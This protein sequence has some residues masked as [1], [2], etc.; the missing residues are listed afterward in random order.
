MTAQPDASQSASIVPNKIGTRGMLANRARHLLGQA[1][2]A[3]LLGVASAPPVMAAQLEL[4]ALVE[5]ANQEHHPGKV[6]FLELVTPDLAAA[7]QF[8]AALKATDLTNSCHG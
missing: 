3:A 6:I 8:Y 1:M 4:P 7:K 5:P 2:L